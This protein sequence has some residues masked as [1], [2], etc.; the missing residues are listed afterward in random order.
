MYYA[1]ILCIVLPLPRPQKISRP[2]SF[3][4]IV[5]FNIS[6]ASSAYIM[7]EHARKSYHIKIQRKLLQSESGAIFIYFIRH[8]NEK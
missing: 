7:Y 5:F 2:G 3:K 6:M 1:Q 8:M 4:N